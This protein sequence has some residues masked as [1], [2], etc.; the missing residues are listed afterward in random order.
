[1]A[2]RPRMEQQKLRQWKIEKALC[3][4]F[5]TYFS[6]T[7]SFKGYGKGELPPQE[8]GDALSPHFFES[9]KDL[10]PRSPYCIYE[11]QVNKRVAK[12]Y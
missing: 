8:C 1:M 7:Y 11:V 10:G 12:G 4:P 6:S 2:A 5:Y 3:F 9:F